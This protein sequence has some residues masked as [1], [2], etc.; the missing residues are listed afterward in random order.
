VPITLARCCRPAP[1]EPIIAYTTVGRG[2]T[3]HRRTCPSLPKL[4]PDRMLRAGWADTPS[5][6]GFTVDVR[7]KAFDRQGLLRDVSDVFT[8][9]RVDVLRVNTE[10]VGEYA[11]MALTIRVREA[12][13]VGRLVNKLGQ[14]QSVIEVGRG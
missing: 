1:P 2:V 14:V 6:G 13:Q 10:S 11:N 9:E 7:L 12:A 4:N 3:V 8:K 5:E